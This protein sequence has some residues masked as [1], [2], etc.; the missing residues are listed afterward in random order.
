M[1]SQI[2][3]RRKYAEAAHRKLRRFDSIYVTVGDCARLLSKRRSVDDGRRHLRSEILVRLPTSTV[4][5]GAGLESL[6]DVIL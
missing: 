4:E 2:R 3:T 1:A 5:L 6:D